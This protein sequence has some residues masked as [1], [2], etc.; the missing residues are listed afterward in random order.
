MSNIVSIQN[1]QSVTTSLAIAEGVGNPHA[2][3]IKLIR[4]NISDL[5]EFGPLGFEI[6]KGQSLPQGGFAKPTEYA[7]LNEQQATLLMTYMRN[8]DVVRAFKKRLVKAFYELSKPASLSRLEI[9][10]IALE[11]EKE[12]E[13]LRLENQA[14]DQRIEK[15]ENF[16]QQGMTIAAFGKTLNGINCMKLNDYCMNELNWLYNESRSGNNKRYRV[17]SNARD[18]YLT[19]TDREIGVHGDNSFMKFEPKLLKAGAQKLYSLYLEGALP[20][21]KTWNGEFVHMKFSGEAA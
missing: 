14:K 18:K 21:K 1:G 15:L 12:K 10:Q 13:A 8:N 2:S 4:Q 7:L 11:S 19:E 16:F 3:V 20:M 9:L 5:E 17:R 6:Q